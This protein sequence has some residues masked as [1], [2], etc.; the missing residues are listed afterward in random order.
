MDP[1]STSVSPKLMAKSHF[2]PFPPPKAEICVA[3][4][5]AGEGTQLRFWASPQRGAT[6]YVLCMCPEYACVL[7]SCLGAEVWAEP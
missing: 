6:V 4:E 7:P 5:T 3:M 2:P 1:N